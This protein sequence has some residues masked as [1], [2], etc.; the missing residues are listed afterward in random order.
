MQ[1]RRVPGALTTAVV[2]AVAG[3]PLMLTIHLIAAQ[4][5]AYG[6]RSDRERRRADGWVSADSPMAAHHLEPKLPEGRRT[7]ALERR[8]PRFRR[9]GWLVGA[10]QLSG[11]TIFKSDRPLPARIGFKPSVGRFNMAGPAETPRKGVEGSIQRQ[12]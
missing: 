7:A 10:G 11:S 6:G 3:G 4:R 1:S 9:P 2:V 12:I 5:H 8:R